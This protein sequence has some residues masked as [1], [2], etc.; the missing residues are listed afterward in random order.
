MSKRMDPVS[1]PDQVQ[2]A[3]DADSDLAKWCGS[4]RIRILNTAALFLEPLHIEYSV[5]AILNQCCGSGIWCFLTS[6]SVIQN[7]FFPDAGSNQE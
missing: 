2:Q 6:R 5:P 7:Q 3:L 1:D 4:D